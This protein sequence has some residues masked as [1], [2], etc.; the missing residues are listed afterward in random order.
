M[1]RNQMIAKIKIAQKQLGLDDAAYRDALQSSTGKRSAAD[2]T[3]AELE[4]A[5]AGFARLGFKPATAGV[6]RSPYAHVRKVYAVW[7]AMGRDGSIE[8]PT[9][10]ALHAFCKRQTGVK[11]AD[12]LS[13]AQASKVVEG[14]KAIQSRA[15]RV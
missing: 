13:A 10:E 1:S 9:K 8:N 3:E 12:W 15:A 2:L 4:R 14:L 11:N 7:G 6:K 5:L